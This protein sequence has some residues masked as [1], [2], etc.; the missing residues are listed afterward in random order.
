MHVNEL[1]GSRNML[2]QN[3]QSEVDTEVKPLNYIMCNVNT[4]KTFSKCMCT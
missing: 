2:K 3:W 4:F 1:W